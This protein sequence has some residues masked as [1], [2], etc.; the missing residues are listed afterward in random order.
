MITLV[1]DYGGEGGSLGIYPL[2]A[3]MEVVFGIS[4]DWFGLRRDGRMCAVWV[5]EP[6]YVLCLRVAQAVW[7]SCVKR[8]VCLL[9]CRMCCVV[10]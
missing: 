8:V 4:C 10:R 9:A 2:D 6:S 3:P 5:G 7:L 1:L